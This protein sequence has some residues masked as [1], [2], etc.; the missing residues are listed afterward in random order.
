YPGLNV[1]GYLL[2]PLRGWFGVTADVRFHRQVRIKSSGQK[3]PLHTGRLFRKRER[4]GSLLVV[5]RERDSLTCATPQ[6]FP[7]PTLG[8][9]RE[10]WG[11]LVLA[12]A[13]EIKSLG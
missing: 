7:T 2:S 4:W 12:G 3:C 8:K 5:M 10:G 13:S 11:T 1:L 9:V 6:A